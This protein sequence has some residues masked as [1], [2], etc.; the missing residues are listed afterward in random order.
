MGYLVLRVNMQSL[1]T[2]VDSVC[3]HK[4]PQFQGNTDHKKTWS[5]YR[6]SSTHAKSLRTENTCPVA[7]AY[8][9]TQLYFVVKLY[10]ADSVS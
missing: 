4:S 2:R 6:V 10:G 1:S 5:S 9:V 7:T 8:L 3:R